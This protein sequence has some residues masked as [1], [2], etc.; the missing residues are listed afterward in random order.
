MEACVFVDGNNT[1]VRPI[2]S[3]ECIK[4]V[5]LSRPHLRR[6]IKIN[7]LRAIILFQGR[8]EKFGHPEQSPTV[9]RNMNKSVKQMEHKTYEILLSNACFC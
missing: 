3:L 9:K 6:G 5:V 2:R 7:T 1:T 8:P 4:R